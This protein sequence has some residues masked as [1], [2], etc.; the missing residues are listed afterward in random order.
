MYRFPFLKKFRWFKSCKSKKTKPTFFQLLKLFETK[1]GLV[2]FRFP[3]FVNKT[4]QGRKSV[5]EKKHGSTLDILSPHYDMHSSILY[6]TTICSVWELHIIIKQTP[7]WVP[8]R[9]S[10]MI[11]YSQLCPKFWMKNLHW[12]ACY[13]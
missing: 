11:S 5:H 4:L 7:T 6:M 12:Y 9:R 8:Q 10:Y 2:Y 13:H 1:V 3:T